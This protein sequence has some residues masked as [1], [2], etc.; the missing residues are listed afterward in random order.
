[1]ISYVSEPG[2]DSNYLH[3]ELTG[4]V[5]RLFFKVYNKLGSGFLE[6]VYEHALIIELKKA[7]IPF[8]QQAP[9]NVFYD[10]TKIGLYYADLLIDEKVIVEI[11]ACEYL[12]ETHEAQLVNYLKATE[13]EVGLLLNFG[14]EPEIKR[15]LLS[16]AFKNRS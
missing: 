10:S 5:I 3:S 8:L 11:K 12:L 7:G 16:N 13:I 14:P 15:R 6:K 4:Q 1:M 9:I 2:Q